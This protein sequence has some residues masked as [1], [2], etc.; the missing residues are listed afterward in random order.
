MS[1]MADFKLNLKAMPFDT[2][3]FKY[4]LDGD[5]FNSIEETEVRRSSVDVTLQVT[6]KDERNFGITLQCTG[7]LTVPCDRCL[8][9]LDVDVDEQYAITLRLE[10]HELDDSRENLLLVP[11]SWHEFDVTSLMRDTVLLAIP[12]VHTHG[13]DECNPSMISV[14]AQ[15]A[16]GEPAQ[17]D[18]DNDNTAA[19]DPRWDALRQLIDNNN[20]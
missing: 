18:D 6:R 2:Q 19:A 3:V 15:H 1:K 12:I 11:E 9:D 14:L 8:D 20:N 17:S 13:D 4:H 10:G 7:T 5:F 16:A